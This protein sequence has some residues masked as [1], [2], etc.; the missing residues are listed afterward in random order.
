MEAGLWLYDSLGRE[1]FGPGTSNI[2]LLGVV[3]TGRVNGSVS[4]PDFAKGRPVIV[5]AMATEGPTSLLP[6]ITKS[7][8]G[9][10]W[11]FASSN[12][13]ANVSV[14]ILYGVRA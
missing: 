10:A 2:T 3:V 6:K 7:A 12:S 9:I 5:S 14:R 4:H 11:S 1:R 13:N 8:S